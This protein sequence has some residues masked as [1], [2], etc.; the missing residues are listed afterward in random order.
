MATILEIVIAAI[1]GAVTMTT[2]LFI[3]KSKQG[4]KFWNIA[5]KIIFGPGKNI[6]PTKLKTLQILLSYWPGKSDEIDRS[7]DRKK[8][9]EKVE[10]VF[11]AIKTDVFSVSPAVVHSIYNDIASY[12]NNIIIPL[13]ITIFII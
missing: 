5:H 8:L 11:C 6:S 9:R 10:K 4:R 3:V 13:Y 7:N 1:I 12:N 2:L